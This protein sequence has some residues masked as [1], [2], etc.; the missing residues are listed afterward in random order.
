MFP[1]DPHL[2]H[3]QPRHGYRLVLYQQPRHGY[4]LAVVVEEQPRVQ[5]QL[6]TAAQGWSLCWHQAQGSQDVACC[7]HHPTS[8]PV[9]PH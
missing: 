3:Q 4:R 9:R 8:R 2:L 5:L 6:M 7:L 1:A